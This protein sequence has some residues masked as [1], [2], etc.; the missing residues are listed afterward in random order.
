MSDNDPEETPSQRRNRVDPLTSSPGRDLPPFE[1]EDLVAGEPQNEE[2][3]DDDGEELFGD[4]MENDYRAM[5]ALDRYDPN[6]LDEEDYDMM[7]EADR[8]AAEAQMRK[9]DRDLGVPADGRMRR[10]LL[11]DEDDDEDEPARRRRRL[12]AD[13][14]AEGRIDDDEED[15]G[16]VESIENLEDTRGRTTREHVMQ[17]GPRTEC[18]NR[19]KNFLRTYVDPRGHNLYR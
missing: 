5:P 17:I 7:S 6:I 4:N 11:Y 8:A 9:R 12:A 18:L 1:D 10:G 13:R 16:M 15:Q 14:A 19:F 2:E 3:E